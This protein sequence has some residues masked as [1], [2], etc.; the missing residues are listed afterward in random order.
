MLL[1]NLGTVLAIY[2]WA[3]LGTLPRG[4]EWKREWRKRELFGRK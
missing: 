3:L 2:G 1:S 4:A